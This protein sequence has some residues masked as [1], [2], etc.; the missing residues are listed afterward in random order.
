MASVNDLTAQGTI[1]SVDGDVVVFNPSGTRYQLRL[2]AHGDAP[3]LVVGV[4]VAGVIRLTA[5]KVRTVSSGGNF[6]TP[7][8]G[9]PLELQ[10]RIYSLDQRQMVLHAGTPVV[11]Q[12]PEDDAVYDLNKGPLEVGALVGIVAETGAVFS[13]K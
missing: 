8:F 13:R 1:L 4:A 6:I 12:L 7:I 3:A 2:K 11:V 10:G 9:P 5:R